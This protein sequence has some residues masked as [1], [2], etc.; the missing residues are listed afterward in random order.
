VPWGR[1]GLK[2]LK[3]MLEGA[4]PKVLQNAAFDLS[5]LRAEGVVVK[6]REREGSRRIG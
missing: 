5:M 6:S 4:Q 2:E 3:I 1:P